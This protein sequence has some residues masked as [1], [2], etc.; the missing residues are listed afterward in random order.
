MFAAVIAAGIVTMALLSQAQLQSN[1]T[2][3]TSLLQSTTTA[4]CPPTTQS[5]SSG[6]Q[7]LSVALGAPVVNHI[8]INNTGLGPGIIG[9]E[10]W[11]ITVSSPTP[12]SV[13]LNSSGS[14]YP[15][16]VRFFPSCLPDVGPAGVNATMRVGPA[17]L[18]T[19][20]TNYT[21][22]TIRAQG[23]DGSTGGMTITLHEYGPVAI[24]DAPGP[25]MQGPPI[26][27]AHAYGNTSESLGVVYDPKDPSAN[28]SLGVS[29]SALGLVQNG[30]L[31]PIPS[32][33]QVNLPRP[34]VLN[35]SLPYYFDVYV[36]TLP[37]HFGNWV[38]SLRDEE[39]GQTYNEN[40]NITTCDPVQGQ[41][42]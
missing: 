37:A 14:P 9:W 25:M 38:I 33:M 3:S 4:S 39:N 10:D 1:K 32:W 13:F 35:T 19:E 41:T 34:F 23:S 24:L 5:P 40:L 42:C 29:F 15:I 8:R 31:Q 28:E 26:D 36:T 17:T 30:T 7:S 16:W 18:D 12:T 21:A 20:Y 22:L 11:P 2:Q 6:Q 27:R